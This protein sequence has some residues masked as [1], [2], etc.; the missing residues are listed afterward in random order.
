MLDRHCAEVGRPA[1]AVHRTVTTAL[2]P[3][4]SVARLVQRCRALA[5]LGVQHVVLITRGRPWVGADLDVA[6]EAAD[7]LRDLAH[8]P[9]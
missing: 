1:D 6:A 4:E 5:D 3:G 2:E 9:G 7:Q 8:T